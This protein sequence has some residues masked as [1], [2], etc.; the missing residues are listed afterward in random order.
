LI[1]N[2]KAELKCKSTELLLLLLH[3]RQTQSQR[4]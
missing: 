1:F 4:P 3:G 2:I